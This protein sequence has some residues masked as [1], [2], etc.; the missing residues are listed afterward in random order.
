[1]NMKSSKQK[2]IFLTLIIAST[3]LIIGVFLNTTRIN[4]A[5]DGVPY[6]EFFEEGVLTDDL[7]YKNASLI[8]GAESGRIDANLNPRDLKQR[9][10][11]RADGTRAK[12][13]SSRRPR[14]L[15]NFRFKRDRS[16]QDPRAVYSLNQ[17]ALHYDFHFSNDQSLARRT[18]RSH[19]NFKFRDGNQLSH[20]INVYL[21]NM[22]ARSGGGINVRLSK[23]PNGGSQQELLNAVFMPYNQLTLGASE[24]LLSPSEIRSAQNL[25]RNGE[26]IKRRGQRKIARG[27]RIRRRGV[28]RNQRRGRATRRGSRLITRGRSLRIEGYRLEQQGQDLVQ[29]GQTSI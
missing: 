8:W 1:M 13:F 24:L 15:P 25:I 20:K 11:N 27:L 22:S 2:Y 14:G 19:Q 10:F 21:E 29:R 23:Q 4:T 9:M 12:S 18:I 17:Y 7:L 3:L 16:R 28:Q 26:S 6:Q 5:A